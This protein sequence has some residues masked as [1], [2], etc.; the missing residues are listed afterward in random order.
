MRRIVSFFAGLSRDV[1]AL[2]VVGR[3]LDAVGVTVNPQDRLQPDDDGREAFRDRGGW[4]M[5]EGLDELIAAIR[6]IV[7]GKRKVKITIEVIE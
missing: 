6:E 7:D 2:D 5:P 4:L 1:G 3:R